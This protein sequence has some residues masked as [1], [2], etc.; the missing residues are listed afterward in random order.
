MW[1]VRVAGGNKAT[2]R[3]SKAIVGNREVTRG[4]WARR[5]GECRM[6]KNSMEL[7]VTK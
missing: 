5:G 2:T 7:T 3:S 4:L 6:Y 1:L